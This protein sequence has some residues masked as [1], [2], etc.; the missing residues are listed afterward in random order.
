[1]EN[2]KGPDDRIRTTDL[3]YR[4]QPLSQQATTTAHFL[5]LSYLRNKVK[6]ILG[7]LQT[8]NTYLNV[9]TTCF[10]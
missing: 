2:P 9:L 4:K 6:G 5:C 3:W 8:T 7:R 10:K 1:M